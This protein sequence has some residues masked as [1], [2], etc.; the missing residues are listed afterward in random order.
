VI[1]E[2]TESK[3]WEAGSYE[4]RNTG[5]GSMAFAVTNPIILPCFATEIQGQARLTSGN[6]LC[7]LWNGVVAKRL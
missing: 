4:Q 1:F 3:M 6:K 5:V 2:T 7:L